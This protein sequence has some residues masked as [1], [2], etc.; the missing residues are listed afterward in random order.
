MSG[1]VLAHGGGVP[2]TAMTLGAVFAAGSLF[3]F[4][5]GRRRREQ[6]RADD[7]TSTA[8]PPDDDT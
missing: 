3:L 4:T 5:E 6:R 1:L 7:A 8:G 2:E